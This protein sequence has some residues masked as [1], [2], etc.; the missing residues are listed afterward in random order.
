MHSS[1]RAFVAS[2]VAEHGFADRQVLEVGSYDVNGSLRDLFGDHYL[3]VDM[4]D[5]PNVDQVVNAHN[6][7]DVLEPESFDL[8]VCCEMLEHDPAFWVSMEQMGRMLRPEGHLL[9]T[10]RGIHFKLHDQPT[11][12][13]RFTMDAGP[14]LLSLAGLEGDVIADPQQPGIFVSGRKP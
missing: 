4:R 10:T 5:G 2:H 13:W 9:L 3:G 14:I 7:T 12:L 6:L 11:D 8:V 1:V